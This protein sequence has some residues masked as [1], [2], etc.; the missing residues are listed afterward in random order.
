[1][2]TPVN[3][4]WT[5]LVPPYD[6]QY[7]AS[8]HNDAEDCVE[9]SFCHMV[10]MLTGFRA[11]PRALAMLTDVTPNGS[12]VTQCL[13]TVNAHGLIPYEAW[14]TPDTFT[15]ET[16]YADI[17]Q[18]VLDQAIPVEAHLVPFNLAV[19]PGWTEVVFNPNATVPGPNHMVAQINMQ[20]Y[21]DSEVGAPIKPLNYEGAKVE[22]Q[23]GISVT[24]KNMTN[25]L[26]TK[27][28][29]EYGVFLPATSQ[30]GLITLLRNIG[31]TPPLNADGT[32]NF[33]ELDTMV[34]ANLSSK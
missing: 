16:Y 27:N 32:V 7:S 8:N 29:S 1:M 34:Q 5:T 22:W 28:G 14:A 19:S 26:I 6:S 10:Y 24:L 23:S 2:N 33:T 11:S 3:N 17:P 15:W 20:E 18:D 31:V 25:A 21:F 30:D 9:E 13:A 12:S 4:D